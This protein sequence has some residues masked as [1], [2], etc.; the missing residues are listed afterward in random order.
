M[1]I[2]LNER[3]VGFDT[4]TLGFPSVQG[5]MAIVYVTDT[6]LFGYHNY[7]GSAD[8]KWADRAQAFAQYVQNHANAGAGSRL[9]GVTYVK[10]RGYTTPGK[11]S[12]TGELTAFA[13]A[14]GYNGKIR[15]YD[16][17]GAGILG[18]AYVEFRKKDDK[19]EM[20][21]KVWADGD[22]TTGP[23]THANDH[24]ITP[25]RGGVTVIENQNLQ[26]VTAVTIAGMKHVH[27]TKLRQ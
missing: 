20:W 19:C 17:S 14:L 1:A 15:G 9:Y 16:L 12:W 13:T 4:T 10:V 8:D 7:G 21:V 3:E 18:S 24:K 2:Y 11:T 25:P 6:G 27:S 23:N 26:V 5:C 22:K